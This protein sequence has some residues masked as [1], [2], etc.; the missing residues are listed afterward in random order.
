MSTK[1]I[2]SDLQEGQDV[3]IDKTGEKGKIIQL[4]QHHNTWFK[5]Q[6]DTE[7]K[8]RSLRTTDLRLPTDP[9]RTEDTK[10]NYNVLTNT[11]IDMNKPVTITAL[12]EGPIIRTND[13]QFQ[14]TLEILRHPEFT[15]SPRALPPYEDIEERFANELEI[16]HPNME[17]NELV[18]RTGG[19]KKKRKTKRKNLKKRKTKKK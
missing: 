17:L 1:K 9:K 18:R 15:N 5:I 4:P 2:Y 12:G 7:T 8:P 10:Y 13:P 6:V 3:I 16:Y 11:P 14:K 19:K